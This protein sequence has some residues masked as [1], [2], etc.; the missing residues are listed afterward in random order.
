M[1]APRISRR[2]AAISESA[3]LAVD[4]KAKA[5]KAAGRP[6][7]YVGSADSEIAALLSESGAGRIFP[8]GEARG[9]AEALKGAAEDSG[10]FQRMA[11]AATELAAGWT[12]AKALAKWHEVLA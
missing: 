11:A 8:N 5:L 6:V 1:T 12:F 10:V 3:T 9:L 2:I 7:M 4:A